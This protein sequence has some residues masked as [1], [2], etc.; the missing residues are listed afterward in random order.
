MSPRSVFVVSSSGAKGA[1]K[2]NS[3]D[4]GTIPAGGAVHSSASRSPATLLQRLTPQR[5]LAKFS[6][7]GGV[8]EKAAAAARSTATPS[9]SSSSSLAEPSAQL[10]H[11][12]S[13]KD[14][15]EYSSAAVAEV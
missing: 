2:K 6:L 4:G 12:D 14:L 7:G 8:A 13:V 5:R 11:S 9:S 3:S 15:S 1:G 10:V